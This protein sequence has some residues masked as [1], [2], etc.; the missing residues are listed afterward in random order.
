M[1][2][3]RFFLEIAPAGGSANGNVRRR[4]RPNE[5]NPGSDGYAPAARNRFA[6][7]GKAI[8]QAAHLDGSRFLVRVTRNDFGFDPL[9]WHEYLWESDA[10]G[11]RG[12]KRNKEAR[13]KRIAQATQRPEWQEAIQELLADG[14]LPPNRLAE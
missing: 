10:G 9:R 11:Y 3:A 1:R 5:A 13:A 12:R 2:K 6:H 14:A 7:G 8:G 4:R